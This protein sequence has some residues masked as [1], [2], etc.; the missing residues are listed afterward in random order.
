ARLRSRTRACARP[1]SRPATARSSSSSPRTRRAAWPGSSPSG[2]KGCI[3]FASRRPTSRACSPTSK[4]EASP[5]STR[6]RAR[7]WPV[8]SPFSIRQPVPVSSSS[9]PRHLPLPSIRT[10]RCA[11]SGSSSAVATRRRR[12]RAIN[13]SSACPRSPSTTGLGA[14]SAGQAA[15]RSSWFRRARWAVPS[16]VQTEWQLSSTA[17]GSVSSAY[18]IGTA[19]ALVFVSAL[20]DYLNPRLVFRV[21]AGLTAVVSLLIPVL[22][23]GH[24]SALLLFG[25]VAVAVAGIYTPGIMLLADRFEP[26]RRGRAVGW[27]LAASS[28]GYV[29]AL[30]P[31][32][33]DGHRRLG[34]RRHSLGSLGPDG[35]DRRDDARE[36]RLLLQL[37]LDA[38]RTAPAARARGQPL[39]LLRA[40]R[41]VGILDGNHGDGE[42]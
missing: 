22:A 31:L 33:R 1:C 9:S 19:V 35:R 4:R 34:R 28:M 40:R 42:A 7:G 23:H 38:G 21:S 32:P 14:C 39:R 36:L 41:F 30:L 15:G 3:T 11:S 17:A 27:F 13:S 26:A 12:P 16:V 18:Q 10:R 25:A 29:L 8:A 24:V 2:A 5:S 6:R 37:R 20:A